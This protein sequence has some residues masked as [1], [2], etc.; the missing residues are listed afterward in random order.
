MDAN[1]SFCL[2]KPKEGATV[3]KEDGKHT[4]VPNILDTNKMMYAEKTHK[5]ENDM[6]KS[7]FEG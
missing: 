2:F 1:K 4:K 5:N 3:V 7:R 6:L